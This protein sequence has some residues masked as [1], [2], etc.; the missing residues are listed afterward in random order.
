MII[1]ITPDMEKVKSIIRMVENREKFLK[2]INVK[3]FPGIF[4]E[5]LYEII[6]ELA[7]ALLLADGLKSIGENSHKD[8]IDYLS[9]Y[10]DFEK[11]EVLLMNDLRIKRNKRLYEGRNINFDYFLSK[12]EK[13][14]KVIKKLKEILKNKYNEK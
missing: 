1:K 6:K 13:F 7:T 9:N 10:K 14:D 5:N 11:E 2:R 4:A 12:K 3:E 8:L